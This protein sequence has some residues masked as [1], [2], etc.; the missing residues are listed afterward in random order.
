MYAV[1]SFTTISWNGTTYTRNHVFSFSATKPYTVT[2]WDPNVNGTVNGITFSPDCSTAY[3]GGIFTTIGATTVKN[4][5]AVSTSTGAVITSF[6]HTANGQV[7]TLLYYNGHILTGGYYT[8][9]NN[10]PATST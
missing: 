1:G 8:S 4:I 3:L 7:E 10:S 9:I 5:A 2:S 6:G